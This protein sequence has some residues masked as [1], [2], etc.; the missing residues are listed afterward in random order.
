VNGRCVPHVGRTATE[1]TSAEFLHDTA[2]DLGTA[3]TIGTD[4]LVAP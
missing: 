2:P 4:W 3:L 1:P